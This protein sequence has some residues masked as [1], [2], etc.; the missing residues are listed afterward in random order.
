MKTWARGLVSLLILLASPALSAEAEAPP[1]SITFS[2]T[3]GVALPLGPGAGYF[4]WGGV[5]ELLVEYPLAPVPGLSVSGGLG[6]GFSTLQY[7][8]GTTSEVSAL[9]GAAWGVPLVGG[10]SARVFAGAGYSFGFVNGDSL[11][12]GGGSAL[13]EAGAG[14]SY[15]FGPLFALRLGASYIYYAGVYGTLNVSVGTA[16]SLPGAARPAPALPEKPSPLGFEITEVRLAEV[17]TAFPSSSAQR[18]VG[19]AVVRNSGT[20]QL[21]R[22]RVNFQAGSVTDAPTESPPIPMLEPGQSREVPLFARFNGSL[23]RPVKATSINAEVLAS[24]VRGEEQLTASRDALLPVAAV[25]QVVWNDPQSLAAFIEPDERAVRD[26]AGLAQDTAAR[27]SSPGMD[28]NLQAAIA[29]LGAVHEAG[30]SFAPDASRP[31]SLVSQAPNGSGPVKLPGQ[32]LRSRAADQPDLVVLYASLF[33]SLG[34]ETAI[35]TIPGRMLLAVRLRLDPT[36]AESGFRGLP[37]LILRDGIVWLPLDLSARGGELPAAWDEGARTWAAAETGSSSAFVRVR[38][39]RAA[40][41]HLEA[42]SPSPLAAMPSADAVARAFVRGLAPLIDRRWNAAASALRPVGKS[43]EAAGEP[44]TPR[45]LFLSV[46]S[47]GIAGYSR[48]DTL[49]IEKSLAFAL[50]GVGGLIVIEGGE[51]PGTGEGLDAA[52]RAVGADSWLRAD[53]SGQRSAPAVRIRLFDL[54]ENTMRADRVV[55]RGSDLGAGA[56]AEERWQDVVASVSQAF[57]TLSAAET[58]PAEARD[59]VLT[60]HAQPGTRISGASGNP[61]VVGK[62]GEARIPLTGGSALALRAE[63]A[64]FFP[65]ER[66]LLIDANRDLY[67]PQEPQSLLSIETSFQNAFSPSVAAVLSLVP[68]LAFLRLGVASY[69]FGLAL[70]ETQAVISLPLWNVYLQ[71]GVYVLPVGFPVRPYATL[72][73]FLRLAQ[74]PGT[75]FRIDPLSPGGL[76]AALGA[77]VR[78]G[79]RARLF[80]E[81]APLFYWSAFPGLIAQ[82][83]HADRP[84]AGY[85]FTSLGAVSLLEVRFGVRWQL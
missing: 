42:P 48:V 75:A 31:Y 13:L 78:A 4:S 61:V 63:L 36:E 69:L 64:G 80:F 5:G 57:P 77:E 71:A 15:S 66:S 76:Q 47:N 43:A 12:Q 27:L 1:T 7:G 37:G 14:L 73:P 20:K 8:A 30:V 60:V 32:T 51:G 62:S 70:D 17:F 58:R 54:A 45:R 21:T 34:M 84:P 6:Y 72:G 59:I 46:E 50:R 82:A 74:L 83:F 16:V 55:K 85:I 44:A 79:P 29:I 49:S 33:E 25:N 56:A 18:P 9:A 65:V 10:L 19:S 53:I 23:P 40:Y 3:P 28:R 68:E 81:Y 2:L 38:D 41:G 67:L 26:L 52:A 35:L 24:A 39:A 11:A 22:V